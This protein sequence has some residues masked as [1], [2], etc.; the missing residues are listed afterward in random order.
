M[1]ADPEALYPRYFSGGVEIRMRDGHTF[2]HHEKVNR[3]AGDR[4]RIVV[5]ISGSPHELQSVRRGCGKR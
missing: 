1:P 3:G 2:R 5:R 4:A